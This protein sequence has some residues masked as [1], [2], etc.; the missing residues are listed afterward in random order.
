MR[1]NR[2][3]RWWMGATAAVVALT[4][5][6]ALAVGLPKQGEVVPRQIPYRGYLDQNGVP[7]T[8][9]TMQF[10][11]EL[12]T[13]ENGGT[14]AWGETQTISV[15][16]GQFTAALG[17]SFAIPAALFAQPSLF[18]QITVD[19][20]QLA[21]RQRLLTVP[22]A[23]KAAVSGFPPGAIIAFGG[24]NAPPG[25][26]LCDGSAL[27]RTDY[28]EL[29]ATIGTLYG[30]GDGST[31]FQVPDLRGRF[32]RGLAS[33]ETRAAGQVQDWATALPRS[34]FTAASVSQSHSHSYYDWYYDE[35]TCRDYDHYPDTAGLGGK[36]GADWD[37]YRC[38]ESRTTATATL[39]H[40][41]SIVGGDP[42]T[43]PV[44]V[45]ASFIIR[46]VP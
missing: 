23:Q 20:Q 7:V 2:F 18:L 38:Q 9:T 29:Y 24:I 46:A 19:G 36:G 43:R 34:P 14:A 26:I 37:N 6:T 16:D 44:N 32:L 12:F 25:W 15:V 22:Y 3:G 40:S 33:G 27:S 42:E 45:G 28:P 11:F 41:H 39:S 4:A 31:T 10:I 21:G 1:V 8:N 35:A 17:D 13:Q 30:A 5:A